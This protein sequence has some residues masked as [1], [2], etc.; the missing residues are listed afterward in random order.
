LSAVNDTEI[1]ASFSLSGSAY[2][3]EEVGERDGGE[4]TDDDD[5]N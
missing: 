4:Y 3:T 2:L 1:G 5:N